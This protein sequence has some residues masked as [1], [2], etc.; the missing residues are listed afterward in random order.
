MKS[1]VNMVKPP[2]LD[3]GSIRFWHHPE[4]LES[5]KYFRSLT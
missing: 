5:V 2:S 3:I 4:I 1:P